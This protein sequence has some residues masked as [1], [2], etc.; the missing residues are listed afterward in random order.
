MDNICS[1]G[2]TED[3][4]KIGLVWMCEDC[5]ADLYDGLLETFS[6]KRPLN[7]R[8]GENLGKLQD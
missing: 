1:C 8:S 5:A 7:R 4:K 6:N 3:L 2:S